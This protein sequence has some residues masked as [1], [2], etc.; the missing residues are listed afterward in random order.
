MLTASMDYRYLSQ[1]AANWT[2]SIP[3][4]HRWLDV[5]TR[6]AASPRLAQP[7]ALGILLSATLVSIFLSFH[8]WYRKE[9]HTHTRTALQALL[10]VITP[11]CSLWP[12]Q[13]TELAKRA[14]IAG[15]NIAVPLDTLIH[16]F[17]DGVIELRNPVMDLAHLVSSGCPVGGWTI[18]IS[19]EWKWWTEALE[20]W[21]VSKS[22]G[23]IGSSRKSPSRFPYF[24]PLGFLLH[25]VATTCSSEPLITLDYGLGISLP[26]AGSVVRVE[27]TSFSP[28]LR[29]LSAAQIIATLPFT[30][31]HGPH[32]CPRSLS[33]VLE[34]L[35]ASGN[36]TVHS[37]TNVSADYE[38]ALADVYE[39][40]SW[41]PQMRKEWANAFGLKKWRLDRFLIALEAA[42]VRRRWIERWAV[43]VSKT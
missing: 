6:W 31:S 3:T 39:K 28:H 29:T 11:T 33:S 32:R 13:Y 10:T 24:H 36:V 4:H 25:P 17:V 7:A 18:C 35:V 15:S 21:L 40:I 38:R 37:V 8:A 5:P 1:V 20:W 14:S 41:D 19:V 34:L 12:P 26:R 43:H 23:R 16:D 22:T 30:L 27:F 2:R 9:D 42:L